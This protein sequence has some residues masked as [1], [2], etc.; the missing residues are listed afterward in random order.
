MTRKTWLVAVITYRRYVRSGMFLILTVALPL[1]MVIAGTVPLLLSGSSHDPLLPTLGLVDTT[2]RFPTL[3]Q[4]AFDEGKLKLVAYSNPAAAQAALQ[5]GQ[6]SGY[7]VIPRRYFEG[8]VIRFYASSPLGDETTAALAA[9]MRRAMLPEAPPWLVERL[10]SPSR[11][12]Y[13]AL[14][15]GLETVAGP[16]MILRLALPAVLALLF[17]LAIFTGS[18]QM[19][20]AVVYEK[21]QRAMEIVITSLRPWELV[22]GKILGMALLSLT[23]VGIWVAAGGLALGLVLAGADEAWS[24]P[25]PWPAL[26]WAVL[27]GL[28]GYLLYAVLGAGLGLIAGDSR[29][30]QQLAGILGFVGLTPMWLVAPLVMAPNGPLAVGLTL[31]PL[32]A[33]VVALLRMSLSEVPSWQLALSLV[34]LL[35][36]LAASIWLV[37]RLFRTA[38]LLY[39]QALRPRQVWQALR[40]A[41]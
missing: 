8:E 1:L 26:V 14:Q 12:T 20:A 40:Q 2:G 16:A 34:L 36:G 28:P 41:G 21:E 22:A 30:A 37:T 15:T 7:M 4:P 6:I 38:M 3:S 19:G 27:L 39:G 24:G 29:Q 33:P 35:L 32:T 11:I 31:F 13:V 17:A 5:Q 9:R 25:V 18:G 23:Q 10:A